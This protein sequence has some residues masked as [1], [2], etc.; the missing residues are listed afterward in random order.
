[1]KTA[2]DTTIILLSYNSKDVTDTCLRKLKPAVAYSEKRLQNTITIIVVDNGSHDGSA[3]MIRKKYPHVRLKALKENIGYAAGNNLA[4]REVKTPFILLMNSDVYIEKADLFKT[5]SHMQTLPDAD[6]L[7]SRWVREDQIFYK[8]G[9]Y[10][11]TPLR[12]ILWSFGC[13]TLPLVNKFFHKIYSYNADFYNHEGEMEWCPP[14]FMLLRREVYTKTKGFDPKLWFHMV[15][16]EWCQRM[17]KS[18]FTIHFTPTVQVLHIGGAS[19][20]GLEKHLLLDN[21]KGLMYFCRKHY[22]KS[23]KRVAFFVRLGLKL[24]T[25]FYTGAGMRDLARTY[26][27]VAREL[28]V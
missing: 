27:S 10:L 16:V 12:I 25:A 1:M 23:T 3:A 28:T 9:G 11:P 6:V 21:F 18:G 26:A 5:L 7:V 15:D 8:Y 4:M 17:K 20:K 13:E 2:L 22:P 24:R 14:S 19:S